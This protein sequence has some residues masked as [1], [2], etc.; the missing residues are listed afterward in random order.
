VFSSAWGYLFSS[1]SLGMR[2]LVGSVLVVAPS[3]LIPIVMRRRAA[4]PA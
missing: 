2:P 4:V 3:V 1:E